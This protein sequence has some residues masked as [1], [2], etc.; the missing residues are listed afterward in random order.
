MALFTGDIFTT[1]EKMRA[2]VGGFEFMDRPGPEYYA[3]VRQR[4]G[5]S[6]SEDQYSRIEQLGLLADEDDQGV[7]LQVFTKPVGDR[8]TLFL[9]IIQR[10]GCMLPGGEQKPGCG[11]FGKGNFKDLFQAIEKYEA[12]LKI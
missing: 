5:S 10:V 1:M 8:A 7:L 11:G 9:E 3:S 4:L 12:T 2:A 6:L